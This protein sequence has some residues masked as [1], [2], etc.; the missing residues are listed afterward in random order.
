MKIDKKEL[1]VEELE[2]I[3]G[4]LLQLNHNPPGVEDIWQLVDN[5]WDDLDC[6]NKNFNKA[7]IDEFYSHPVWLLNALFIEQDDVCM[8]QRHAVSGWMAKMGF[9]KVLDYGGGGG[10]L[11]RL[12]AEKKPDAIVDVYEPYPSRYAISRA[13]DYPNIRFIDKIGSNY[14][15]VISVD[16][17][18]HVPDPLDLFSRMVESARVGGYMVVANHFYPV[19]KCHLPSTFHLRYTFNRFARLLGLELIG[20]CEGS[21]AIIYQKKKAVSYN[22]RKI[23][24]YEQISKVLF[25][26]LNTIHPILVRLRKL[27]AE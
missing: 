8:Q 27:K 5:V 17:L 10:V 15:C 24:N 13:A 22:W 25:V 20:P 19:V 26:L 4:L 12:V 9:E 23:R 6:D 1:S 7:E 14:D 18:E 2:D 21:H 3:E 11:S 16:V